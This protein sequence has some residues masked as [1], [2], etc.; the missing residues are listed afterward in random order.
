MPRG[1]SSYLVRVVLAIV[2]IA[3]VLAVIAAS[4]PPSNPSGSSVAHCSVTIKATATSGPAPFTATFTADVT[5]PPGVTTSEPEWQFGPFG[6]GLDFNYTY[7]STVTHSWNTS[8]SYGVHVTVPD[9]SGQ[10]CW[11]TMSVNVT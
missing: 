8:G 3:V 11:T 7:G 4:Q 2:L 1:I 10:G 9:S 6:S 5:A